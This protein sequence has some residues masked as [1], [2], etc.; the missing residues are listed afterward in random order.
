[1][2]GMRII[3]SLEN[4]QPKLTGAFLA[5]INSGLIRAVAS[6][7]ELKRTLR[8]GAPRRAETIS[9]NWFDF[10]WLAGGTS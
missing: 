3:Y 4:L 7:I 1:M 9:T 10:W 6:M 2:R 8:I 5:W